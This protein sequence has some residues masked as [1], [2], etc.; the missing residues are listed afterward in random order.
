MNKQGQI[1]NILLFFI[2]VAVLIVVG[3][4]IGILASVIDIATDTIIPEIEGIGMVGDQNITQYSQYGTTPVNT[5]VQNLTWIGGVMYMMGVVGLFGIAFAFRLTM[6]RV[7]II[8]FFGLAILMIF[9]SIL[10]SNIYEDI[11][12][13]GDELSTRLQDQTILSYLVLHSPLIF[14]IVIFASGI[15]LFSG[16]SEEGG[17]A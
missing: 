8:L 4:V 5:F 6:N 14:T 12:S 11:Y 3:V 15:V 10:I 9:L 2:I 13:G 7:Y 16:V 1:G 17:I